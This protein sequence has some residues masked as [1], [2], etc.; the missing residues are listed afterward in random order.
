[1]TIVVCPLSKVLDMIALHRPGRVVSML[2]PEWPFPVLGPHYVGRHL[3]LSFHDIQ[4]PM[5]NLV[6]PTAEHVRDLLEFLTGWDLQDPL[7]I[8]CRAGISRST[9]AAYIAACSAHAAVDE[10]DIALA[11]R[12]AA[13]LARP[14]EAL[15]EL[16]DRALGRKGRMSAAIA[17]TGRDL[18]WIDVEEGEPFHMSVAGP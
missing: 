17:H 6:M 10:H 7:L 15:V 9:A 5:Q 14:N 12:R 4:V 16:A 8:H 2:D 18:G 11:L 13:P 3:R 1:M